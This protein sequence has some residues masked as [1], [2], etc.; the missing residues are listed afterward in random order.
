VTSHTN[1]ALVGS[2]FTG[3]AHSNAWL[4]QASDILTVIGGGDPVVPLVDFADALETQRVLHAAI[5]SARHRAPVA[6]DDL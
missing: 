6:V 3:R 1:V 4:N 5:E 2:K